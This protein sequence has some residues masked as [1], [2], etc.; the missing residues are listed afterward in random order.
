MPTNSGSFEVSTT[1]GYGKVKVYYSHTYTNGS[2]SSTFEIT[3]VCLISTAYAGYNWYIDGIIQL[4]GKT[5]ASSSISN[6]TYWKYIGA[7]YTEYSLGITGST[8]LTHDSSGN[9]SV[10]ITFLKN[11]QSTFY[12]YYASGNIRNSSI[13]SGTEKVLYFNVPQDYTLTISQGTGTTITVTRISSNVTYTG[14]LYNNSTIWAGDV[15]TITIYSLTGYTLKTHTV[16]G[17]TFTSGGSVSVSGNIVVSATATANLYT[18][19]I[20]TNTGISVTVY[21]ETEQKYCYNGSSVSYNSVLKITC[22]VS[23]GY[24]L[25][26]LTIDGVK[27]SSTS[28]SIVVDGDTSINAQAKALGLV[29]IHNGTNY[30]AFQIYIFNGSTWDLYCP[31]I[32]NGTTWVMCA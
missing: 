20:S 12:L 30:E 31:Y 24:E 19:S 23:S 28:A 13:S 4:N 26:S 14:T 15:L 2:S 21:N 8:T 5:I 18:L 16:N 22:S 25:S 27:Y 29:Y 6:T 9:A 32:H 10:S 3:D 11:T 1:N 17:S 7:T